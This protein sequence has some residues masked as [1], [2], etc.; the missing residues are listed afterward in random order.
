[1]RISVEVFPWLSETVGGTISG[2]VVMSEE[3]P[4]GETLRDL[5][6]RLHRKHQRFGKLVYNPEK[7]CLAG[8]AQVTINGSIYDIMGGMDA[9]LREGDT[10]SFLPEMAGG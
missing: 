7:G 9:R 4:D 2:K 10:V 1:M 8:H 6:T 5:L 3:L